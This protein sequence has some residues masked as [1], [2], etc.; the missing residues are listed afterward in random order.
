MLIGERQRQQFNIRLIS[1]AEAILDRVI[2]LHS[3]LF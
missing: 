2:I 3:A 1:F